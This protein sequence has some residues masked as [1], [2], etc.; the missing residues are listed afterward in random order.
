MLWEPYLGIHVGSVQIDLSSVFVYLGADILDR[1]LEDSVS[2]G[3][4]DHDGCQ[5]LRVLLRF[6][7]QVFVVD[8]SVV[9][10]F[11][12]DHLHVGHTGRSG[13]GA[14]GRRGDQADPSVVLANG[15]EILHDGQ[16]TG[17]FSVGSGVGLETEYSKF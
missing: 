8:I 16:Q 1:G 5:L 15:L 6:S 13:I 3:I 12:H 11:D 14:M 17:I 2:R 10:S 9:V 4:G 7:R